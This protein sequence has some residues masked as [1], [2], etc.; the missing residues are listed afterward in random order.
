MKIHFIERDSRRNDSDFAETCGSFSV[1][2][3]ILTLG[4]KELGVYTDNINEA[5]HVG[6]ADSL[7]ISSHIPDK[8]NFRIIFYDT[9]NTLTHGHLHQAIGSN[10]KLVCINQHTSDLFGKFGIRCE[11]IGPGLD[12]N[13]WVKTKPFNEEFS[14]LSTNFSNHRSSIDLLVQAFDIA[15]RGNGDV[16]LIIKNTSDS[17]LL[18]RR[19]KSYQEAGNNIEYINHRMTF[20]EIR[21][22][23]SRCHVVSN[24]FRFSAHGLSIGESQSCGSLSIVGDFNPSNQIC[25]DAVRLKPSNIVKIN[26]KLDYLVN[27]WGL[28]NCVG[29]L[30]HPEDAEMY[31]YDVEEYAELLKDI[32]KNWSSKY[33]NISPRQKIV[34]TWDYKK[35]AEKLI[36][37]LR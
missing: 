20:S 6:F 3:N 14:I 11:V 24:I 28:T 21:D 7:D 2:Q 19:I 32:Y 31:D 5:T 35:S 33:S 26:N 29:G 30:T 15:F 37:A 36:K 4:L 22:L 9:I 18:A 1:I 16:K 17:E 23:F 34:E 8:E 13:Y 25:G 12:T 10:I 27:T